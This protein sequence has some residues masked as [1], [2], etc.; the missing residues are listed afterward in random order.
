M[1]YCHLTLFH[2]VGDFGLGT[3]LCLPKL[4]SAQSLVHIPQYMG[5]V[6][7]VV[8]VTFDL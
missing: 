4:V 1:L 3:R 7:V 5:A 8:I 6:C 2:R